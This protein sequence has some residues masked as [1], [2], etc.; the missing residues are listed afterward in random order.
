MNPYLPSYEYV[1]DGEPRVFGDRVYIFGSHD[2]FNGQNFC[3]NDYVCW[4]ASVDNLADWKYEGVIYRKDQDPDWNPKVLQQL[5]APDCVQGPDGRY[6]LYY[7]ICGTGTISVGVSEV[8]QGPYD[9]YGTV[10]YKDG[11]V[12]S[13]RPGDSFQFDPGVFVE[14]NTV[15]L[16]SGFCMPDIAT[17]GPKAM[18]LEPDMITIKEEPEE[19]L[20]CKKT[21]AGTG[22]E[23]HEFFEAS[24][25]RKRGDI[26]YF[27]YSSV[28]SHE[29]CYATGP[30]P[31]G[32]FTYGGTIVSIA[33]VFLNGRTKEQALNYM[34]NTHGSII[35]I[36]DDWYVFYH[37]QTNGHQY[38]RQ[39]CA[40]R[41]EFTAD[42]HIP[43]VE[44]T[45]QGLEAKPLPGTGK[46]EARCACNLW[47]RNGARAYSLPGG[48]LDKSHPF[49][50]Q[51]GPDREDNPNQ[52]IARMST[53][54]VAGFKYFDM[55]GATG[56]VL[57][58]RGNGKGTMKVMTDPKGPA[59]ASIDVGPSDTWTE[60]AGTI[61]PLSGKQALYFTF[62]GIGD[63]DFMSFELK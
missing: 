21:A 15:V 42:G 47:G 3:L 38:S 59:V 7:A 14:G 19:I 29:L 33:D 52:H 61:A 41:I 23:G 5:F 51:D 55:Q 49:F 2:K 46:Y 13:R 25:M 60:T 1:P 17:E 16:Y 44:V 10:H 35:Q 20:P 26:Y 6:Y 9:Y 24:S 34:G 58:T 8:P 32:P 4:S 50:T 12:L 39:A 63:I 27:I 54:S 30:T 37:R 57:T 11:V 45:T 36:K 31:K 43:Q 48:D 40:E 62:E 22:F 53:G 18:V 56:L 28:N